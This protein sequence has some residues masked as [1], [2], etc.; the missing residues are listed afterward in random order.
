MMHAQTNATSLN[1]AMKS[2]RWGDRALAREVGISPSAL[3]LYRTGERKPRVDHALRIAK[4]LKTPVEDLWPIEEQ[5]Q[6]PMSPE[7][8]PN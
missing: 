3:K 7:E 8:R 4:V 6:S 2:Q 5:P 1:N